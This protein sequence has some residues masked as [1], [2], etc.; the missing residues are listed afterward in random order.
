M[1]I[2]SRRLALSNPSR[3]AFSL[4]ETLIALA[5]TATML[6][7]SLTA[8]D[9]SFKSYKVT[10]ESASTN[11]VTRLVMHRIM[12]MVRTGDQFGPYPADPLDVS[13][14]P[15]LSNAIEFETFRDDSTGKRTVVRLDRR[16]Q[17]NP[18]LG[19]YELWFKQ[20]DFEG[21]VAVATR[22]KPLITGVQD[23]KFTLEYDVG[24][25]LRRA[26]VDLSVKPNDFQGANFGGDVKPP[27]IRLVS[28]VSPRRLDV[29]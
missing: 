6:T 14:N 29:D 2:R 19:P 8:L 21:T 9:A 10:T 17:T 22:E 13:Q 20:V 7:A 18:V 16:D 15:V 26:T 11:V 5:I 4:I 28:S 23:V 12:T 24:P 1:N 25:R 3:P 27:S